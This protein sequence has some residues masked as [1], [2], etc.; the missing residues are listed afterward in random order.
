VFD[1]LYNGAKANA[2]EVGCWAH[3]RRKFHVLADSDTRV[4]Y[5]LKLIS[6]LYRLEDLADRRGLDAEAREPLRTD[7]SSPILE[8]LDRWLQRTVMNEPPTSALAKA[9]AYGLKQWVA[10]TEFLGDGLLKLDNNCCER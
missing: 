2:T 1:R 4:A 8:R 7:R 5:P 3:A 10:L 6:Q 9:C